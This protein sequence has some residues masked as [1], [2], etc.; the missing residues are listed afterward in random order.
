MTQTNIAADESLKHHIINVEIPKNMDR[1]REYLKNGNSKHKLVQLIDRTISRLRD[2]TL[3]RTQ[4]EQFLERLVDSVRLKRIFN[5]NKCSMFMYRLSRRFDVD[6]DMWIN[7]LQWYRKPD[8]LQISIDD[9]RT[10]RMLNG[11]TSVPNPVLNAATGSGSSKVNREVAVPSTSMISSSFTKNRSSVPNRAMVGGSSHTMKRRT[12]DEPIQI[13]SIVVVANKT[14]RAELEKKEMEIRERLVDRLTHGSSNPYS[15]N[16]PSTSNPRSISDDDFSLYDKDGFCGALSSKHLK[17]VKERNK[18]A[19]SLKLKNCKRN[20]YACIDIEGNHPEPAEIAVILCD[21]DSLLDVKIFHIR[22]RNRALFS[23]G[24]KHC[25]GMDFNQLNKIAKF[26][27]QE[28]T[29]II[30]NWLESL[31]NVTVLSADESENSDVSEFVNGW[32][33]K[34]LNVPLPRWEYR[35][36]TQAYKETQLNK[37]HE[38]SVGNVMCPYKMLHK[39]ANLKP[40]VKN[41]LKSGSHCALIDVHQL[42]L[43]LK[44]DNLWSMIKRLTDSAQIPHKHQC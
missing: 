21:E 23:Q 25:H 19:G 15:A 31:N 42:F 43:H 26:E 1:C 9:R 40:T 35:I 18:H 37:P 41:S 14:E 16:I 20:L 28:A 2:E 38:Y 13:R 22:V 6:D 11:R 36:E 3:E 12:D 32:K 29:S 44:Y 7:S 30:R 8:D 39:N 5:V 33:L 34:Y 4:R 17:M 27:L 24:S 10:G